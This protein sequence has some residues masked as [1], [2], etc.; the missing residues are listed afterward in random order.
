MTND[1]TR[2][3]FTLRIS[4]EVL[5]KVKLS[6]EKNKRSAAKDIEYVLEKTYKD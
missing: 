1:V 4:K 5:E 2:V 3:A 6:A